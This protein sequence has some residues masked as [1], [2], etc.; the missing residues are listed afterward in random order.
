[1]KRHAFS[2]VVI[3]LGLQFIGGGI[4]DRANAATPQF[5]NSTAAAGMTAS[6]NAVI[7]RTLWGPAVM[8]GGGVVGDFDRDGYQDFFFLGGDSPDKLFMNDGDG[9]FTDEAVAWGIGTA[10]HMGI[11]ASVGDMNDDGWLDIYVTSIGPSNTTPATGQ[12]KLYRNN[13]DGTFTD[14]AVSAGVSTTGATASDG[15]SSAFGDYDLDGDLDLFVTS[16]L[17]QSGG[18]K[19][20]RNNGNETFTDVTAAAGMD[21]ALLDTRGFTPRFIDMDGDHYPEL[22]LAADF[23]TSKY[24]VNNGDGT[25][26]DQTAVSGTGLDGNGMGQTVGDF[27]N[28]GLMDWYVTSIYEEND[29][30]PNPN[31]PGDG[32]MLYRCIADNSFVEDGLLS[33]VRDGGW[34]WGTVA[35]DFDHDTHQDL[36]ETNGWSPVYQGEQSYLWHNQGD[37]SFVERA[38]LSGI[39]KSGLGRGMINFDYDNDGDQDLVLMEYYGPLGLFENLI[40]QQADTNWVRVFLD[41]SSRADLA[42]DGFGSV[43]RV[44]VGSET[45]S[46]S[47]DGGSNYL[48]VSELSAHFGLGSAVTIDELRVEWADGRST[49]L[50]TVGANQTLTLEPGGCAGDAN[51]DGTVDVNDI[52]YVLFR[53]GGSPPEGDVNGDSAVD[54]NDISYVLFRLGT[55]LEP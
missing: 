18:N 10:A 14:I 39:N 42:P 15:W 29:E 6:H 26:T 5:Q 52:S 32:N 47:I 49:V 48:S 24:F 46:R 9:T 41:T 7:A 3:G 53:L 35:V 54:V 27:D 11:G 19:L 33:G 25:F 51:A 20:F 50:N 31:V 13:G 2:C 45:Y 16:W 4:A 12:H 22:L 43:V 40:D 38:L 21:A 30:W 8:M 23:G 37:G 28:D 44:T 36:M 1:M 17:Y 55:C 34:G